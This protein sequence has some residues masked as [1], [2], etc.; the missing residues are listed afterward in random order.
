MYRLYVLKVLWS[1]C[2]SPYWSK[3]VFQ[4]K[5][6][7]EKKTNGI[8]SGR[9]IPLKQGTLYKKGSNPLSRD[10]KKK[11]V[12]VEENRLTIFTNLN[13]S[14]LF[15]IRTFLHLVCRCLRLVLFAVSVF[16]PLLYKRPPPCGQRT[17]ESLKGLQHW[18]EEEDGKLDKIVTS[19]V[20]K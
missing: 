9:T 19:E 10:W 7:E 1:L 13:V 11:Y 20:G 6:E 8:G 5:G 15:F 18:G 16:L 12:V 4:K 2:A 14:S 3:S 17:K